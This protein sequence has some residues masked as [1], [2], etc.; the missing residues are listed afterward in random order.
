MSTIKIPNNWKPRPY[1]RNL[2]SFLENEGKRAV[3]VWHR[4]GGKD[5]VCLNYTATAAIDRVGSYWHMLP[6]ANQ[7]R[8]AIWGAVDANT[9]QKRID[10]AFPM[11][12][13]KKT[14]NDE[15]SIEFVNGSTWQ[16]IGSD[17]YNAL[18]GSGPCGIVFS[19][20]SLSKPESW[21]YLRQILM[22]NNGWALFIYTPRGKNHGKDMLDLAMSEEGWFSEVLTAGQTG[23]FTEK[24]LDQ[25][26]REL[27]KE[28]GY[29]KGLAF[30]NQEYFCSFTQAFE[31]K[32]VYPDFDKE[33][34]V[35]KVPLLP[36]AQEGARNGG[37]IIRGWDNTGLSPACIVTYINSLGQ[38]FILKEFCGDDIGMVEF[39]QMVVL[40]CSQMFPG[41]SNYADIGDPAGNIRDT[42]KQ[43]PASYLKQHLGL[44]I[45]DGIQ[46]FKTRQ[47]SVTKVLN[48][49]HRGEPFLLI[50]PG[51]E[52]VIDGFA[53]G[54]CFPEIGTTK[55]YLPEP[56]KNFYSHIH[57]AIQY[58][59][60]ILFKVGGGSRIIKQSHAQTG[61][62]PLNSNSR[63]SNF[64]QTRAI[65]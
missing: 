52:V 24:Q 38:W 7:A 23:V 60:T 25:E 1:Q 53:G 29:S 65:T 57:D 55:I 12:I 42:T 59:A 17:N 54:Y 36:L 61:Y 27:I 14:R 21:T 40:W 41:C 2:W 4:R 63:Q 49:A 33:T 22:E 31:G 3:A 6:Q 20:Y 26:K 19:E 50:D 37:Q 5:D 56:K 9:G 13:R 10:Q 47:A 58:P 8:K 28:K 44:N 11:E 51:C 46:T 30:F 32:A 48:K 18:V 34:H 43:S 45:K 35:S 15:M 64:A 62:D 16:V 39:G